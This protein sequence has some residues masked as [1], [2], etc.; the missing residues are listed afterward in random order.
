MDLPDD[1]LFEV[2][3]FGDAQDTA[4]VGGTCRALHDALLGDRRG[5]Q[6]QAHWRTLCVRRWGRHVTDEEEQEGAG[7]GPPSPPAPPPTDWR[8]YYAH[9]VSWWRPP[10]PSPL[11]LVQER[12]CDDPWRLLACC[13]LA[14][15]TS[16]GAT[17]MA[18]IDAFMARYPTPSALLDAPPDEVGALLHPLGLRR[19]VTL[20]KTARGFLSPGW[21]GAP[22]SD[23]YG[24]GQ[25]SNDSH[26]VFTV[27][28]RHAARVAR[29][30][31]ADRNVRAYAAWAVRQAAAAAPPAASAAAP[32][33]VGG[34]APA[35]VAHAGA[36]AAA[37]AA[38][39]GAGRSAEVARAASQPPA[40]QPQLP[41]AARGGGAGGGRR[42]AALHASAAPVRGV[43]GGARRSSPRLTPPAGDP[44]QGGGARQQ[45]KRAAGEGPGRGAA[46]SAP[47]KRAKR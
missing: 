42:A 44:R 25:F 36:A 3:S 34:G 2:L 40:A 10:R 45:R 26:L 19:E 33:A 23:L 1:I 41:A 28:A 17:V 13:L 47:S 27:G 9:R 46:T 43:S 35:V 18:V 12:Y 30:L 5:A 11:A 4:R 7:G 29:D 14:S 8:A 32:A 39:A 37:A 22:A 31:T 16:G 20:A 15:R 21:T 24:C 6:A 38:P